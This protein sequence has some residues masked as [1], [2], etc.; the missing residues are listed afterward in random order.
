MDHGQPQ[1]SH[2]RCAQPRVVEAEDPECLAQVEVGLPG[3]DDP[4]FRSRSEVLNL[5]QL[6]GLRVGPGGVQPDALAG[7]FHFRQVWL[8]HA[9]VEPVLE[10]LPAPPHVGHDGDDAVA[11]YPDTAGP[12]GDIRDD[13]QRDPEAAAA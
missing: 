12:V 2:A 9:R 4:D 13:L 11:V 10:P 8:Q 5:V 1:Q 3:G 6:V 7:P